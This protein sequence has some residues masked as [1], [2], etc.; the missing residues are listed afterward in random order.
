MHDKGKYL[1]AEK[2]NFHFLDKSLFLLSSYSWYPVVPNSGTKVHGKKVQNLLYN[3]RVGVE[4]RDK[5]YVKTITLVRR[6]LQ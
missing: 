1:N 6:C 3:V 2:R 5:R 4:I